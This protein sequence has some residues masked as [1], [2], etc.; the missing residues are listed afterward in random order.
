[1][2]AMREVR[3]RYTPARGDKDGIHELGIMGRTEVS[4]TKS[5]SHWK[6]HAIRKSHREVNIWTLPLPFRGRSQ[7][8]RVNDDSA[9]LTARFG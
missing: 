5:K 1:M 7:L 6:R 9:G 2:A 8:D 4:F 3:V